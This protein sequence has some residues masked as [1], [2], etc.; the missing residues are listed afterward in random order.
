MKYQL[1]GIKY[2]ATAIALLWLVEF[3]NIFT[4]RAL[5]NYGLLPRS[6]HQAYGIITAPFIHGGV[7]HLLGNSIPLAV[8]AFLVLQTRRLLGVT[9]FVML[10]GGA[11]VWLFGRHAM[12]IGASGLVLGYWGYLIANGWINR[13]VKNIALSIFAL[14]IY[15]GLFFSLIDFRGFVSF[16]G[17]IAGFVSGIIAAYLFK[18]Q[19]KPL[20]ESL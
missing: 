19:T 8:L 20:G 4:G 12:H 10:V 9:L 7:W 1:N 11:L 2:I 13:S 18:E 5:E 3:I 14:F 17:H 15:G 16:E 6:I